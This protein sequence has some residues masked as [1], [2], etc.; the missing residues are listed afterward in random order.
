MINFKNRYLSLT[1]ALILAVLPISS[2]PIGAIEAEQ[3][4]SYEYTIPTEIISE[5]NIELYG[6]KERFYKG[7][8]SVYGNLCAGCKNTIISNINLYAHD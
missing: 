7:E 1:L 4:E 8:E 3:T 6:H 2:L 5:E